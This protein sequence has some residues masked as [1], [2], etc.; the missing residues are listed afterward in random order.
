MFIHLLKFNLCR[1]IQWCKTCI[2]VMDEDLSFLLCG[3]HPFTPLQPCQTR[4]P[5]GVPPSSEFYRIR[6]ESWRCIWYLVQQHPFLW[7]HCTQMVSLCANSTLTSRCCS[8]RQ[9]IVF[10]IA[11]F[12]ALTSGRRRR[13]PIFPQTDEQRRAGQPAYCGLRRSRSPEPRPSS[14]QSLEM[15]TF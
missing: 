2:F 8:D 15:A 9:W 14:A 4:R 11:I 1:A 10:F 6:C 3:Q 12:M 5:T 13:C 7:A